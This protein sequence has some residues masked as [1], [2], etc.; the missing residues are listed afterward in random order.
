MLYAAKLVPTTAGAVA[1]S[2]TAHKQLSPYPL[3]RET[4][5][6]QV[7][8]PAI[9]FGVVS[10]CS[11]K[12]AANDELP[13]TS[14]LQQLCVPCIHKVCHFLCRPICTSNWRLLSPPTVIRLARFG[15]ISHGGR[16]LLPALTSL[17]RFTIIVDGTNSQ[18]DLA[19]Q[20]NNKSVQ[21]RVPDWGA[22]L[23]VTSRH[24]KSLVKPQAVRRILCR[25]STCLPTVSGATGIIVST[26]RTLQNDESR[27]DEDL[28][29]ARSS[30][31]SADTSPAEEVIPL[32][33]LICTV[34]CFAAE[35]HQP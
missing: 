34:S 25:Q 33:Y 13:A 3:P 21:C 24:V 32:L 19:C 6:S 16:H 28:E 7:G 26:N 2:S 29:S 1:C 31:S 22:S 23:R 4:S 8:L 17:Y 14:E 15:R 9:R 20:P 11:F 30:S 12:V 10:G 35:E 5:R 18:D 27:E